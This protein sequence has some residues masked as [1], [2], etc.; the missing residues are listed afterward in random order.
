M[1]ES[2]AGSAL[3]YVDAARLQIADADL[4]RADFRGTRDQ[5][6]GTLE[7]VMIDPAARRLRFFVVKSHG[8]FTSRRFLL[9]VEWPARID[10]G[11]N[12]LCVDLD[13]DDLAQFEEFERMAAPAHS[14]DDLIESMFHHRVA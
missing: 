7:G 2:P 5:K 6:I 12:A 11:R 14:D 8:W 13:S 10:A 1:H 3:R 4:R 9:P